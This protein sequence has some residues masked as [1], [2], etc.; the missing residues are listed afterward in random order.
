M[1][2]EPLYFTTVKNYKNGKYILNRYKKGDFLIILIGIGIAS[3]GF[4]TN[5]ILDPQGMTFFKI[6][7]F[8]LFGIVPL[9][10]F[11]SSVL[12]HSF[13]IYFRTRIRFLKRKKKY[14]WKGIEKD[15]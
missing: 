9:L 5:F 3:I 10:I 6:L 8:L 15:E 4:F 13:F 11:K 2:D 14:I 7:F 12:Y 1:S